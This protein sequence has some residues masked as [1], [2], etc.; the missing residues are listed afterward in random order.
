MDNNKK[1]YS[2][3]NA[4]FFSF[5]KRSRLKLFI[6]VIAMLISSLGMLLPAIFV[7]SSIDILREEGLGQAFISETLKIL[8]VGVLYYIVTFYAFYTYMTLAFSYE[9][10]IRQEYFDRIQKHSLTFHDENNSSKLLATGMTEIS[11]LRTGIMPA[12]RGIFQ[13]IFQ[14]AFALFFI[15]RAT[16]L[17]KT[18]IALSGF[19]LYYIIAIWQSKKIIPIREKLANTV[20]SLTEESQEIFQ[21]IEVVRSL[22]STRREVQKFRK[23]SSEYAELA[24]TEGQMS[25]FYMPNLI[26]LV[27]TAVLFALTLIDVT[28]GTISLGAMLQVIGLLLT[29]QLS[30]L[31]LPNMF[32]MINA[33]LTNANRIWE[34][35]NW[36]DPV[37][38]KII[39]NEPEVNWEGDI[40][41]DNVTF[42]YGSDKRPAL[43]NIN[44]TIPA[45][46]KI[47]LIGGPGSGKSTFLKLLLQLY[48]STEGAI[49]I[50]GINYK[51]IS[52]REV[53]KNVSRV[54]QEI[55]LFSG[56]IRDNI[57]FAKVEATDEEIIE[58][59]K[60]AQAF[61]F[62]EKLPNGIH[63]VIGE[64]G[65]DISG[66]QKQRLAI[67]RAILADPKI[68]LL[69]D[70][71]SALDSK[72][73]ALLRL[74][75]DNL[76]R[77]R[78]TITVTQRLNTLVK[79]DMVILLHKGEILDHGTHK[80]LL[81]RCQSYRKIFEL[82]PESEQ[83]I[84]GGIEQ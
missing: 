16:D 83:I 64:R 53:R 22:K 69:D 63:T 44:L 17:Y 48:L 32:L 35:M 65:V 8:A 15:Y 29:I 77:D 20:G 67:A 78:L 49:K 40:V 6:S 10:D 24:K 74:A 59:A 68:L 71:A 75:L 70:S 2:S 73:E 31:M 9:R 42:N 33:A 52:A 84:A 56:K 30:S 66:G 46:S 14:L 61:E 1:L 58:A 51:D 34:K 26:M 80:E 19:I 3:G 81:A 38:D 79:A 28:N 36:I 76:S 47:A 5:I 72:T 60:A 43:K 7:G 39:E 82:L 25:A 50:S 54:E 27:L 11:Q 23:T 13:N 45:N 4:L 12:A 62:I 18:V 37:P 41:F 21:G 55:F 57:G